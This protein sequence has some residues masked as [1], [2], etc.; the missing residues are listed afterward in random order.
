[1]IAVFIGIEKCNRKLKLSLFCF[2]KCL[3]R[4][5]AMVLKLWWPVAPFQRLSN[6]GYN[7]VPRSS[8]VEKR[9][10]TLKLSL[11]S[12]IFSRNLSEDQ[13]KDHHYE[14]VSDFVKFAPK[15]N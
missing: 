6:T 11:I 12:L 14:N 15:G 2:C 8:K 5:K 10:I 3:I 4:F 7:I 13:K 1:M 9:F